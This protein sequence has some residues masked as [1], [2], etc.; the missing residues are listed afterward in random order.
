MHPEADGKPRTFYFVSDVRCFNKSA[1]NKMSRS[2]TN[3]VLAALLLCGAAIAQN[4]DVRPP[5]NN[6]DDR[7][8]QPIAMGLCASV[9]YSNAS[10]PNYRG[11]LNEVW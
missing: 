5:V 10:F 8:C 2:R 9:G 11:H 7:T 6:E 1:I 3:A 4:G